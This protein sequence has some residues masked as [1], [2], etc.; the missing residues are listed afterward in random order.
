MRQK[1]NHDPDLREKLFSTGAQSLSDRELVA[2]LLG[3]GT[4]GKNVMLMAAEVLSLFN[5]SGD[6]PD[7]R[8][9]MKV[10]GMGLAKAAMFHAAIELSRRFLCPEKRRIT[11]PDD[12]IPLISHY[13]DRR[14]EYFLCITL[15]GA[16][17][18]KFVRIVS[19]G[20]LNRTLVHPREIFADPIKDRAAAIIIA[21]NHPSGNLE[22]SAEDKE[23]TERIKKA[24]EILGIELLDHVIFSE[25]SFFSFKKEGML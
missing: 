5:R 8:K 18:V 2:V 3:T 15:N 10:S 16:N 13:E 20:L 24:G 12:I 14:Q 9:F 23:I 17:E 11:S 22:P 1:K 6:I 4:R 25:N 19:I 7:V 21:H